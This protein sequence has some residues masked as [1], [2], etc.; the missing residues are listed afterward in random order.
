M[1]RKL[2]QQMQTRILAALEIQCLTG[3]E[4]TLY[5]LTDLVVKDPPRGLVRAVGRF[6]LETFAF[7]KSVM[8]SQTD[9]RVF[10]PGRLAE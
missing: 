1:E 9:G 8:F 4:C 2:S 6:I 3:E 7:E 5:E 10:I